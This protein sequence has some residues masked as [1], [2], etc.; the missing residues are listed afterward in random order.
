M[1]CNYVHWHPQD[2]FWGKKISGVNLK[3]MA[4]GLR[5]SAKIIKKIAERFIIL[6]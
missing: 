5:E 3:L 2:F 4:R 6:I 1:K